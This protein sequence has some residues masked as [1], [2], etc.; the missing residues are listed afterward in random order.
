[1]APLEFSKSKEMLETKREKPHITENRRVKTID[2]WPDVDVSQLVSSQR[3]HP[4]SPV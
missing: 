1:M 4:R 3:W 2:S